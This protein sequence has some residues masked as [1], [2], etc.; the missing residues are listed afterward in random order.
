MPERAGQR[1]PEQGHDAI[2]HDL[3]HRAFVLVHGRHHAIEDRIEQVPRLLGVTVGQQFHGAFEVGK[4]H[5]HLLALT[6]QGTA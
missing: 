6:F 5:G 1:R 3:I 2:P 4:Q